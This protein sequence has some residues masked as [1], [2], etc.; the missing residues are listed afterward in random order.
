MRMTDHLEADL[1]PETLAGAMFHQT[2]DPLL[3]V[4]PISERI[5][6]ANAAAAAL[7][8]FARDELI[9]FSL[10]A[11]VRHEQEWQDWRL[12]ASPQPGSDSFL[13]RTRRADRWVPISFSITRL[14]PP[15]RHPLVVCRLR[16][17]REQIDSQRRLL[18][19]EAELRRLMGSLSDAVY[20]GRIEP[21]GHWRLRYVSPR[22]QA[23]TGKSL[24]SLQEG[25]RARE[26]IVAQEDRPG[27]RELISRAEMG[28]PGEL[29]YRV[30]QPAGGTLWVREAIVV[31]PD[32][33]GLMVHGI[34]TDVSS[35]KKAETEASAVGR[36]QA[37]RL[38]GLARL[39]SQVAHDFNNVI[40]G[41][42]GNVNL[43]RLEG[44]S[45]RECLTR[46]EAIAVRAADQCRQLALFA[47]KGVS[48]AGAVDLG[49][50]ARQLAAGTAL[51]PGQNLILDVA[52][53]LAP[54]GGDEPSLGVVLGGLLS[55]AI[56]A[57]EGGAG[58][59]RVA[60]RAVPEAKAT[61]AP[62]EVVLIRHP[63]ERPAGVSLCVEVSD[64]GPGLSPA[65]QER[66]FEPYFSTRPGQRGLG[67][68]LA[69]G[70][71][72]GLGGAIEVVSPTGGGALFRVLLPAARILRPSV[73]L[74]EQPATRPVGGTVLLV[75]DEQAVRDVT[76]RL[77]GSHGCE[78][79]TARDGDEAVAR[80]R[81]RADDVRAVL[82][83]WNLPGLSGEALIEQLRRIS[84]AV[85]VFLMS[86]LTHHELSARLEGLGVAGYLQ[87]PFRLGT[88]IE[89]LRPCLGEAA[90]P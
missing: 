55:N 86:G 81:E 90:S 63:G 39:A 79:V 11:L 5:L 33:G 12:A 89:L 37:R 59:V 27:W 13:V 60:V 16:D 22:L 26:S 36:E 64:T 53:G 29:E 20:S 56:E 49:A 7:T 31:T 18:R 28:Q 3:A 47:G 80:L 66:L 44:G 70:V 34:V 43:A 15:D 83:D 24:A 8:E 48:S 6:D 38:D 75:E 40:T 21:P 67:L 74:A 57:L 42:L 54:A 19:A 51:P 2:S 68:A 4:N 9:R 78:V 23:L 25:P 88:L 35:R 62:A 65:V 72:R 76:C 71:V 50:L 10:R 45:A 73:H 77:L 1:N 69:L 82:M 32:E 61:A 84:P 52:D 17:R 30:Q 58:D 14:S 46:I 87:K 85:P 41:V